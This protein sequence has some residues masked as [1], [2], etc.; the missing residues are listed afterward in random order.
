VTNRE[1]N[2]LRSLRTLLVDP[3]RPDGPAR[4]L[5]AVQ[6]MLLLRADRSRRRVN[7]TLLA[8]VREAEARREGGVS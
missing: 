1:R 2:T 7:A 4:R 8:G 6:V 5:A 3:D